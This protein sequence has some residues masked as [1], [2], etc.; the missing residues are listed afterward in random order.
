V[1]EITG[2]R[3]LRRFSPVDRLPVA[4]ASTCK[5]RCPETMKYGTITLPDSPA[6]DIGAWI[7][8]HDT[9]P[10]FAGVVQAALT[11]SGETPGNRPARLLRITP[12]EEAATDQARKYP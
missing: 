10:S 6:T 3:S 1:R 4:S 11:V 7:E 12:A 2:H 8:S 5:F 9:P